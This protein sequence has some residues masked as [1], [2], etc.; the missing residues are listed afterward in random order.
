MKGLQVS[1]EGEYVEGELDG[2]VYHYSPSGRL[3]HTEHFNMGA[4]ER[5][6]HH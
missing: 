2:A 6:E 3:T 5:T 1:R 4:I